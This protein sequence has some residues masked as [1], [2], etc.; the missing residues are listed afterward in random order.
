M[1]VKIG[2]EISIDQAVHESSETTVEADDQVIC[3]H[4]KISKYM[5]ARRMHGIVRGHQFIQ[6]I[7]TISNSACR[8]L[9]KGRQARRRSYVLGR[10]KGERQRGSWALALDRGLT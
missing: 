6:H 10:Q 8:F 5:N 9:A 1:A 4:A 3:M 2:Q 7:S